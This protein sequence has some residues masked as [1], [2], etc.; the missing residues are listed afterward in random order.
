M[1]YICL[2]AIIRERSTCDALSQ[3]PSAHAAWNKGRGT[4]ID[5][6]T[7]TVPVQY[8]P[9]NAKYETLG[10]HF[11]SHMIE[12]IQTTDSLEALPVLLSN[13]HQVS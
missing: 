8:T 11:T 6:T 12:R 4:S 13:G 5:S 10:M 9:H 2:R 1:W 7:G 3:M